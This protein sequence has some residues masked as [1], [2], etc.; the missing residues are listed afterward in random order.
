MLK[1]EKGSHIVRYKNTKNSFS[2]NSL[3]IQE[4]ESLS[5]TEIIPLNINWGLAFSLSAEIV[6]I[7]NK[8]TN[9]GKKLQFYFPEISQG[10][11]AYDKYKGQNKE[12]IKSRAYHHSIYKNGYKKWLWGEDVRRYVTVWNGKEYIDYCSGIANPRQPKFFKNKRL[13]IR[14]ITN[15]SIYA[16]IVTEEMYN[17]PA[18]IIV[19]DSDNYPLEVALSILNSK[20]GTF[21]HFNHSPKATK[22][23]FPKILVQDIKDFPLPFIEVNKQKAIIALVDKIL[24]SKKQD[25]TADTSDWEREIDLYVY[26]LYGLT[27]EEAQMIDRTV[28]AKEFEKLQLNISQ[29]KTEKSLKKSEFTCNTKKSRM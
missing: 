24:A 7:V 1:T 29:S 3:V 4:E 6:E 28:T 12:V 5:E 10:L 16:N 19:L 11:I 13:L 23:E 27:L 26:Y 8:I 21:Y 17:D 20:L 25:P 15:P 18:I 2:F 14:E 22:G 9:V